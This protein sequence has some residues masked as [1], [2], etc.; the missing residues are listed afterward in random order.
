MK[1]KYIC[2]LD[3]GSSRVSAVIAGY[4]SSCRELNV[5]GSGEAECN[6]LRHGVVVNIENTSRA[7][8][9]AV[10]K[11]EAVAEVKVKEVVV[12]VNGHHIEGHLQQGATKI[13]RS[14][15]EITADDVERVINSARAVPLSS[16]KQII[17][18]IPLDFRVDSQNGVDNPVGMEGSHLEAE[19]LLVTG[20]SAPINNLD[21]CIAR[22]GLNIKATVATILAPSESVLAREEKEL[23]C[24]LVDIGD[25]TVNLAIFVDGKISYIGQVDIG[26]YYITT[27]LAYGLRTSLSEAKR[28]K[29]SYGSAD[30]DSIL[31]DEIEYVGVDGHSKRTADSE[32]IGRIIKPRVDDIVDFIAGEISRSEYKQLIPGGIVLSGGGAQLKG[33]CSSL[34][35]RGEGAPVRLGRPR[36]LKGKADAVSSPKYATAVGL[37]E[38]LVKTNSS[39]AFQD[40][41]A[42]GSGGLFSKIKEWI[43]E[44]F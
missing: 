21:K 41:A 37:I 10:E 33:I 7:I 1:E 23:G 36:A 17:H 42:A 39:Y 30:K 16:D 28:I 25:Q 12:N 22:A 34:E 18:A 44:M 3:V 35:K 9:E 5:I 29:E 14:D 4:D 20:D 27:D 43:E 2:G 13:P 40:M 32:K 38:Y 11:A 8:A 6:G 15:R 26:S 24:A 19:V 31:E